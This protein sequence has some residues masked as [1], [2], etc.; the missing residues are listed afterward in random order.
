MSGFASDTATPSPEARG[1][2]ARVSDNTCDNTSDGTSGGDAVAAAV[3]VGAPVG[4][5]KNCKLALNYFTHTNSRSS[6][7]SSE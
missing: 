6:A 4:R 5:I 7:G 2:G 3:A 1:K